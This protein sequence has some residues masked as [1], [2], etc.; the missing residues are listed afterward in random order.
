MKKHILMTVVAALV[1]SAAVVA[2]AVDR[3]GCSA[4]S[5]AIA[6]DHLPVGRCASSGEGL[7]AL[8]RTWFFSN[9]TGLETSRANLG[10]LLII[11]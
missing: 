7:T 2:G 5:D 10:L 8:F 6:L 9:G 11:R 3:G 4:V 1:A